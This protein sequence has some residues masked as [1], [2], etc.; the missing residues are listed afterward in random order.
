MY[1]TQFNWGF[2]YLFQFHLYFI[3]LNLFV[4]ICIVFVFLRNIDRNVMIN[5][6]VPP[7]ILP[8]ACTA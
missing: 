1:E 4:C 7:F 8:E 3:N 5:P 2:S 6:E